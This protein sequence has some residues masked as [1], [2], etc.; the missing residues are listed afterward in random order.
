MEITTNNSTYLVDLIAKTVTG[1]IFRNTAERYTEANFQIG[2]PAVFFLQ[3]GE[4][5]RTSNVKS[6]RVA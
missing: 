2:Y 5:F 6:V 3:N 4:I 1:G